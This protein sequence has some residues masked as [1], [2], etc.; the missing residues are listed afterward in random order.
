MNKGTRR[1]IVTMENRLKQKI[2][3]QFGY[4]QYYLYYE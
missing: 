3:T 4:L 1:I 2:T